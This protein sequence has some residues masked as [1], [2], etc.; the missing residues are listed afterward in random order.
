MSEL[1]VFLSVCCLMKS[2][3]CTTVM[4]TI[5]Q[6][7]ETV[8]IRKMHGD[9]LNL[10]RFEWFRAYK[11]QCTNG[12]HLLVGKLCSLVQYCLALKHDCKES[13]SLYYVIRSFPEYVL[14]W[15][16]QNSPW[17]K[18]ILLIFYAKVIKM[19][20]TIVLLF[21]IC[22]LPIHAFTLLVWFYPKFLKVKTR[23]GYICY[24]ASYFFC[25]FIS[26]AHSTVNPICYCFMSENFR[27]STESK[28][29]LGQPFNQLF[30]SFSQF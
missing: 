6:G 5:I 21:A 30:F 2:F 12:F 27:V 8:K 9:C 19:L 13:A 7:W 10:G 26:M 23:V 25:H 29:I 17:L 14:L 11:S 15:H 24:V 18:L 4:P 1:K 20:M 28:R 16:K 3:L 22:W